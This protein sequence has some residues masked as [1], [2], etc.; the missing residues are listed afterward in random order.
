MYETKD[1][2]KR[3]EFNGGYVRD[4]EEGKPRFD[5]LLLA[6]VPYHDQPLYREAMLLARGADKYGARNWE[7]ALWTN[8]AV[9]EAAPEEQ[10]FISSM[11]RHA[12]QAACGAEDEDH[13]AAVTY[14]ARALMAFRVAEMREDEALYDAAVAAATG[15]RVA[16]EDALKE[17]GALRSAVID[18]CQKVVWI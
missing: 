15:E 10:R 5:L 8:G 9:P 1:S 12:I 7:K 6:G 4:T 3:A 16:W 18:K 17:L 2:G 14:N 13:L 11:L